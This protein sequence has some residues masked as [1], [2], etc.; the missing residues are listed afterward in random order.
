MFTAFG[1]CDGVAGGWVDTCDANHMC[2]SWTPSSSS[3]AFE[4]RTKLSQ[5]TGQGVKGT[6]CICKEIVLNHM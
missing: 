3:P 2:K 5:L 1:P 6:H 4:E